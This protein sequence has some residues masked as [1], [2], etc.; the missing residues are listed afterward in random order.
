MNNWTL[1]ERIEKAEEVAKY[2]KNF[3]IAAEAR[4]MLAAGYIVQANQYLKKYG[5]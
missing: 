5:F 4:A 2:T 1:A 3:H